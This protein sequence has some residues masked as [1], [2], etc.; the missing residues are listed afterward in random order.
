MGQLFPE[1]K[2][3][4]FA[5]YNGWRAVA[6]SATYGYGNYVCQDAK[7]YILLGLCIFVFFSFVLLEIVMKLQQKHD[8]P[9]AEMTNYDPVP[10]KDTDETAC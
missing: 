2:E 10:T 5:H 7:I 3:A 6:F 9:A 8:L 4:A 1:K